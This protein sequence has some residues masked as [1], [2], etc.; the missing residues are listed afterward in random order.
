V[1]IPHANTDLQAYY[2][3][4]AQEYDRIYSKPERQDDLRK[5]E[6]WLPRVLSGRAILEV[7][8]GTGYWTQFLSPAARCI[9]A[10]DSSPETLEVAKSRP[11]NTS[12]RFVVGDAYGLP[13]GAGEFDAAFAGFWLSHVPRSRIAAFLDE[14]HRTLAPGAR[15]VFLDNR[16][17]EGSSTPIADTD[18]DG[19]TYQLRPLSDGSTHRILKN[20]PTEADLRS[21]LDGGCTDVRYHEWQYFW[22]LEYGLPVRT[23]EIAAVP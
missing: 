14:L 10:V 8:C 20:F 21:A 17:V 23:P 22:A 15:V 11:A 2:A 6:S 9:T 13:V 1:T 18:A 4:R 19:N 7:A 3:A 16:Y 12:V 5:I